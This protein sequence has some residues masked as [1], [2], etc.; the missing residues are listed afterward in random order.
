MS[1]S[2]NLV[3]YRTKDG[4]LI[5]E[6][7]KTVRCEE[8]SGSLLEKIK[9]EFPMIERQVY[10]DDSLTESFDIDCFSV[11]DTDG[12]C[13]LLEDMFLELLRFENNRLNSEQADSSALQGKSTKLAADIHSDENQ[14]SPIELAVVRF[15][16][17]TG[18]IG[19]FTEARNKFSDDIGIVIKLG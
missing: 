7:L 8:I 13:K 14:S 3:L 1:T 10:F 15:R 11:S 17:L 5:E 12:V 19:I 18:I 4:K 6:D 16:I 9:S 2:L